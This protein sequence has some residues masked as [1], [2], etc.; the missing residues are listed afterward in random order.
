MGTV[1]YG[2]AFRCASRDW[3]DGVDLPSKVQ[4]VADW[5][6]V[7]YQRARLADLIEAN[8]VTLLRLLPGPGALRL[9]RQFQALF[10][11]TSPPA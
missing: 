7:E 3:G 2:R 8:L 5:I 4:N 9:V 10:S 6:A 1:P 11:P